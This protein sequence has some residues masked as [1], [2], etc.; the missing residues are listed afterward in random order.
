MGEKEKQ[1]DVDVTSLSC[2]PGKHVRAG[3]DCVSTGDLSVF[4]SQPPPKPR[5]RPLNWPI[6][7]SPHLGRCE[8]RVLQNQNSERQHCIREES[9]T[10][11][12]AGAR[13]FKLDNDS[14]Q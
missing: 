7:T 4:R 1:E 12:V 2:C 8:G 9:G 10:G 6:P 11:S 13:G 14:P 5:S 3:P